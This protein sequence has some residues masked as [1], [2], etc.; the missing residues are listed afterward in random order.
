MRVNAHLGQA[1]SNHIP[2]AARP[3]DG[4]EHAEDARA[5][6]CYVVTMHVAKHAID[7]QRARAQIRQGRAER[8]EARLRTEERLEH[9][10]FTVYDATA[11]RLLFLWREKAMTQPYGV[12]SRGVHGVSSNE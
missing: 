2:C 3:F 8:V 4:A 5:R 1:P 12:C 6:G 9:G 7:R 11:K 10:V